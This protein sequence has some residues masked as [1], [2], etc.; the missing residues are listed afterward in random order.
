MSAFV[1]AREV[2]RCRAIRV[3]SG[4]ISTCL[5]QHV[6]ELRISEVDTGGP[7]EGRHAQVVHMIDVCP[8]ID[9]SDYRRY[10]CGIGLVHDSTEIE[11][12]PHNSHVA[13][14]RELHDLPRR[15]ARS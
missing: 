15:A 11:E 7:Q 12:P 3:P 4:R 5:Q 9:G 8:A 6:D 1:S 10:A 13:H 14:G 2:K